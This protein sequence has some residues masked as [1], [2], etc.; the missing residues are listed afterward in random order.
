MKSLHLPRI[1]PTMHLDFIWNDSEIQKEIVKL[2]LGEIEV[3][4]R[5][6]KGTVNTFITLATRLLKSRGEVGSIH[7]SDDTP[8]T[9]RSCC[10]GAMT[11]YYILDEL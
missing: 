1:L 2:C 7:Y 3:F 4:G 8:I 9:V 5:V 10:K 11:G 6:G